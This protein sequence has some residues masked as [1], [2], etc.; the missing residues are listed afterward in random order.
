MNENLDGELI[1]TSS[2]KLQWQLVHDP[3][4]PG[5][6]LHDLCDVLP[7]FLLERV[8]EHCRTEVKTLSLLSM[9]VD[10]NVRAGVSENPN[11][12]LEVLEYLVNDD[13][14]DVRYTMAENHN[15]ARNLLIS[16][17]DDDNPYVSSRAQKTLMRLQENKCVQGQFNF[18]I[19]HERRYMEGM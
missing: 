2:S 14:P 9:H 1:P 3:D 5:D 6:V 16:L 18:G 11:T 12:P 19:V 7:T 13:C 8:A 17:C 4:T 15:L 10:P